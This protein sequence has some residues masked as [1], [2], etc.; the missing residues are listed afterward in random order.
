V[1]FD[2]GFNIQGYELGLQ[3]ENHLTFDKVERVMSYWEVEN[4]QATFD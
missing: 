2:V 4:K 3:P 1:P